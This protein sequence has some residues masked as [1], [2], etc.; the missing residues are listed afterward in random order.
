MNTS[1]RGFN[2][3][4]L[5]GILWTLVLIFQRLKEPIAVSPAYHSALDVNVKSGAIQIEPG[6]TPIPVKI[7]P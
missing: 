7:E 1:L 3:L 2:T 4:L 5:L 6:S